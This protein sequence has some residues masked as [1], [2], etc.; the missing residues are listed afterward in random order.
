MNFKEFASIDENTQWGLLKEATATRYSVEVNYRSKL[1]EVAEAFAKIALGYISAAA[2]AR[3]LHVKHVFDA[4]PL[5]I[6]V[7]SRNWDDGEWVGIISFN[8]D[9]DGG[10][11]VISK[12]FYNNER[13]S[14]SLQGSQKCVGTSA[15]EVASELLELMHKVKDEPDRHIEKLNPAPLKRGPKN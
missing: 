8:P 4:K 5:R 7:S 2:K 6:L 14:I 10:C 1:S 3:N 12:G 13:R 11:F 15:S 9:H